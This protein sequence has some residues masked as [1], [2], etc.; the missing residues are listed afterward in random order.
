MSIGS[1]EQDSDYFTRLT[2]AP[3]GSSR[4]R[5][6][7]LAEFRDKH[8]KCI[9]VLRKKGQ[10][11]SGRS[12]PLAPAPAAAAAT[13]PVASPAPSS[14]AQQPHVQMSSSQP[15]L[16]AT[17]AA[18]TSGP[19]P[20][21]QQASVPAA[22][23]EPLQG[24]AGSIPVAAPMQVEDDPI[25][26]A[27]K[28][29]KEQQAVLLRDASERQGI[30]AEQLLAG[31]SE[32]LQDT[33]QELRVLRSGLEVQGRDLEALRAQE[34]HISIR[35]LRES[36]ETCDKMSAMRAQETNV[37]LDKLR[38]ALAAQAREMEGRARE[39]HA[40]VG[41]VRER[42]DAQ[43]QELGD[44]LPKVREVQATFSAVQQSLEECGGRLGELTS[45][46]GRQHQEQREELE[47][48][49]C[50]L[51]VQSQCETLRTALEEHRRREAAHE[52]AASAWREE[53]TRLQGEVLQ[54]TRLA[55]FQ[56]QGNVGGAGSV[57]CTQL[58]PL[59]RRSNSVV[60]TAAGQLGLHAQARPLTFVAAL[61]IALVAVAAAIG[62]ALRPAPPPHTPA[63]PGLF[64]I[65]R[66]ERGGIRGPSG[67]RRNA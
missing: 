37:A 20:A 31:V 44:L 62:A 45:K 46:A 47:Q 5:G 26:K 14:Q 38:E 11:G 65:G 17:S 36:L 66:S 64:G 42:L 52:A 51:D 53:R 7:G 49:R 40:S 32:L 57:A 27:L 8:A 58:A 25:L 29:L 67:H 59:P 61:G 18:A 19:L 12:T 6:F 15:N 22:P 2:T 34:A 21:A 41:A 10:S 4:S 23:N 56:L 60:E 1:S 48:L 63:P 13:A 54:L 9:E 33:A 39:T 16:V 43:G 35:A 3:A 55:E 50:A 28:E 24:A 30:A